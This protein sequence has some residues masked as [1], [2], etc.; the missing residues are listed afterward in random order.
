MKLGVALTI[1]D[2]QQKRKELCKQNNN[3]N[4]D[5]TEPTMDEHTSSSPPSGQFNNSGE[6]INLT[7]NKS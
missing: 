5:I 1:E 3:N 7:S 6:Q 4:K 2:L